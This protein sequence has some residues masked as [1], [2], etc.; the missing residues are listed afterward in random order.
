V[1]RL[2]LFNIRN[3]GPGNLFALSPDGTTLVTANG[4]NLTVYDLTKNQPQ[5]QPRNV[6]VEGVFL[7]DGTLAFS[8]DSK[9]VVALSAQ[10]MEDQSLHFIDISTGKEVRQIDNDE[11]FNSLALSADGKMLAV[12]GQQGRVEIW[13]AQTGDEIRV[14]PGVVNGVCR[15]LAFSADGRMLATVA[16]Q[17]N[18]QRPGNHIDP[19]GG[20]QMYYRR[21]GQ[22]QVSALAFSA[23][24]RLLTAGC[25]DQTIRLWDLETDRELP[26]LVGHQ[27]AVAALAFTPDGKRLVSFDASGL[28][29]AWSVSRIE[30]AVSSKLPTLSDA[31]FAELWTNLADAD[32]F[33]TYRAM[34]YLTAEPQR[35][36]TLLRRELKPVPPGD[37]KLLDQLLNDL[38][39]PNGGVRRK[40]MAGLRQQGEAALA[41]LS[42]R[43][44]NGGPQPFAIRG[45]MPL[46]G[47]SLQGLVRKLE[48]QHA[49]PQR[50]RALRAVPILEEIGTDEAK[51]FLEQLAG[52]AAGANLT[53][54][55]RTSL[56]ALVA[57][58]T[59]R[60]T[61][62]RRPRTRWRAN[63]FARMA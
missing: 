23:D 18:R 26:P 42:E 57:V 15:E 9:F 4:N 22:L 25:G 6:M 35:A 19:A 2:H 40:A 21:G 32:A 63:R 46:Q 37:R 20:D 38:Q 39:N 11:S 28:K 12:G 7:R 58:G 48:A 61:Q 8:G 29:L 3:Y 41:A 33:Q 5:V 36:L 59:A 49:T 47:R 13:D 60:E 31:E 34:R 52:G 17:F 45:G 14:L 43:L 44:G 62:P 27:A 51:Q 24:G 54:V 53:I 55:A 56:D 10:H 1:S 50:A 30:A 16:V